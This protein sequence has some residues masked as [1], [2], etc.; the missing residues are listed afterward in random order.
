V[1]NS[2]FKGYVRLHDEILLDINTVWTEHKTI[3]NEINTLCMKITCVINIIRRI[4]N[5]IVMIEIYRKKVFGLQ[6]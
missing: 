4:I 2:N 6:M 3:D 1:R 5:I